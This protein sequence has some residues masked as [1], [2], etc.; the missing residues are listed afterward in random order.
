MRLIQSY[1]FLLVLI[2]SICIEDLAVSNMMKNHKLTKSI[3]DASWP[4]F[5]RQLE[6]KCEWYGRELRVINRF[7]P[8]SKTC[9][10]CGHIVSEMPLNVRTLF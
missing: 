1:N 2:I 3:A 8:T 10:S 5:R 7:S 6:Y 4:E 9:S